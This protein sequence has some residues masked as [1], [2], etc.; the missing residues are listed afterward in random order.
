MITREQLEESRKRGIR[1]YGYKKAF[2]D[3]NDCCEV[4]DKKVRFP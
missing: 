2:C 4:C 1:I 3:L